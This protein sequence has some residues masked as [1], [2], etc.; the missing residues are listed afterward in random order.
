MPKYFFVNKLI[1]QTP[2]EALE[3]LRH[4]KGIDSSVPMT[5]AGR[6]DPMA[7]GLLLILIGDECK[8]KD[9]YLGLDKEYEVEI[10]LGIGSDTAD[11]LG[12]IIQ[13][14][15][16]LDVRFENQ[17]KTQKISEEI[18]QKQLNNLVG[19]RTEKYPAYSSKP[20]NGKPLFEHAKSGSLDDIEMPKKEIEVYSIDFLGQQEISKKELM[21]II[22]ERI[23]KVKGNF[24]QEEIVDSWKQVIKAGGTTQEYFQVIKLKVHSSSGAYMRTLAEKL[25][26]SLGIHAL[27]LSIK[28]TKIGDFI[29]Q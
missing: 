19:K 3:H 27:A 24:R 17:R 12:K 26:E 7:E 11:V 23:Q 22:I 1:G 6:L 13:G 15:Q 5:Y 4:E 14:G 16:I 18:I 20:V 25:G 28:R 21:K 2:L 10:L 8:M 29:L 9:Q